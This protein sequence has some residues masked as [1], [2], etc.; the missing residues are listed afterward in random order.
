MSKALKTI[1]APIE[2][3]LVY[4]DRY[5]RSAMRSSVGLLDRITRYL[6]RR[7]GK[8]MRP[9]MVLFSAH[10]C[11]GITPSTYRGAAL[12]ELLH[13]ATLIHDDVVDDSEKRRGF[14]SINALWKNKIAVLVGDFLLSRGLLMAL[15]HDDFQLLKINS[16]AI[17]LMSEGELLQMEKARKL[18]IDEAVYFDIIR[19]KTASLFAC[20]CQTGAATA[21]DDPEKVEKMRLFGEKVG[22]AFQIKDDLFD[23]GDEDVG[24]PRAIDIKEQKM[25][26]PLIHVL[27]KATWTERRKI[28][29]IIRNHNTNPQKVKYVINYV[30]ANGGIDYSRQVMM[31]YIQEAEQILNEFEDSP[32]RTSLL[33]LMHYSVNRKK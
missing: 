23:Y 6:I 8:Q 2:Q 29:N 14:F 10:I 1:Q 24:K 32:A 9:M 18:N 7:K 5:F 13:T 21:T 4:F 28:I 22:I 33:E 19:Q 20:C 3:E 16:H 31:E 12:V 25:T 26:L 11:G 27:N 15:E 17:K 30:Y